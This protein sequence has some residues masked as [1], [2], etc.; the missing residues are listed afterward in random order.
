MSDQR[1]CPICHENINIYDCVVVGRC[2]HTFCTICWNQF[3]FI[4]N[5]FEKLKAPKC[6]ACRAV[7]HVPSTIRG[8]KVRYI[9]ET[10][11]Y[12]LKSENV[13]LR[14]LLLGI[15]TCN[16]KEMGEWKHNYKILVGK[17]AKVCHME[18]EGRNRVEED[19][20]NQLTD[21][22]KYWEEFKLYHKKM[23]NAL[24]Q[25][26]RDY[27]PPTPPKRPDPDPIPDDIPVASPHDFGF[28]GQP[29]ISSITVGH[30]DHASVLRDVRHII[31]GMHTAQN[32]PEGTSVQYTH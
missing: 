32:N 23:R 14:N 22:H 21:Y 12:D 30:T 17:S 29:V 18:T 26:T 24:I 2:A 13:Y 3:I 11:Q 10:F 4:H 19:H 7:I 25:M 5:Q 15:S 20:L 8:N 9:R 1:A 28:M 16:R 31:S 27:R 6:P